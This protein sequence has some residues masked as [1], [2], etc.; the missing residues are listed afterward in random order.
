MT[1]PVCFKINGKCNILIVRNRVQIHFDT[2]IDFSY[3]QF[4]LP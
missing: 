2:P 1:T 3:C 4:D